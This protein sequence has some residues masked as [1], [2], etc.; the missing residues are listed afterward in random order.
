MIQFRIR[1]NREESKCSQADE[2][3]ELNGLKYIKFLHKSN[4]LDNLN[5]C[6]ECDKKTTIIYLLFYRKIDGKQAL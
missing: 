3:N 1:E 5:I 2:Q 6:V 4:L